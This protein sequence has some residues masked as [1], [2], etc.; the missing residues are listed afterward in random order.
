M[1]AAA[2]EADT[3]SLIGYAVLRANF[4]ANAPHYLDNFRLRAGRPRPALP[5][6]R[7]GLPTVDVHCSSD[8]WLAL[9]DCELTREVPSESDAWLW[10]ALMTAIAGAVHPLV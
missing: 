2:T 7:G 9:C 10:R 6:R 8:G 5:A 4:N 3:N 1:T